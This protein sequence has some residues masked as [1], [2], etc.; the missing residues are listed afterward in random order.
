[1]RGVPLLA[2]V[3]CGSGSAAPFWAEHRIQPLR[4]TL[5]PLPWGAS[6]GGRVTGAGPAPDLGHCLFR[7]EDQGAFPF[8]SLG[9][10]PESAD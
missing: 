5:Y 4:L 6:A 9:A 2:V 1:M 3:T 8:G 10:W 7:A